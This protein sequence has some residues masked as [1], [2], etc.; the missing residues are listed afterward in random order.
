MISFLA[1]EENTKIPGP[2]P[3]DQL[4]SN[5]NF[6]QDKELA[7]GDVLSARVIQPKVALKLASC[8]CRPEDSPASAWGWWERDTS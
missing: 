2:Q 3:S 5:I 6:P 7:A 1:S 8:S 4:I